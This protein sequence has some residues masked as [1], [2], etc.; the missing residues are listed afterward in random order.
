MMSLAALIVIVA[1]QA[2][3]QLPVGL[4]L[5]GEAAETFLGTATV[6]E[7]EEFDSRG[8][9]KP[10]K[11]TL[12]DGQ[13]TL[14]AVFKDI[15]VVYAKKKLNTGRTIRKLK[16]SYRHEIAAYQLDKLLGLGLIPPSV[17]RRIGGIDGSL[18]LWV[19]GAMTEWHR[20]KVYEVD[21]PDAVVWDHQMSTVLLIDLL[22]NDTDFNN[23]LNILIDTNWRVY[24]IDFSRAFH[25]TFRI[26]LKE[27]PE[28]FRR[29]TVEALRELQQSDLE[30]ALH[31]W[32]DEEQIDGLWIRRTEILDFVDRLIARH[33]EQVVLFD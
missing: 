10:R 26:R 16:D 8:I 5:T 24:R 6:I 12:S 19:N 33:G 32:L 21:P 18:T 14:Y 11:V 17:E 27:D 23:E 25:P 4:P 31:Q 9:T 2:T 20:R 7:V 30:T 3:T 15:D 13:Q 1:T 29:S 28:R 22:T